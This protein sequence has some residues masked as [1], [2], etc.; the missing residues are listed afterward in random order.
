MSFPTERELL[1]KFNSDSN[2]S[3][4]ICL[5]VGRIFINFSCHFVYMRSRTSLLFGVYSTNFP[6]N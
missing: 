5:L 2:K 3:I 4:K 6:H 1:K